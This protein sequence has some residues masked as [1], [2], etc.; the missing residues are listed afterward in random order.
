MPAPVSLREIIDHLGFILDEYTT[1][2]NKETG[3]IVTV[4]KEDLSHAEQADDVQD[5]PEWQPETLQEAR[6]IPDSDDYIALPGKFDIHEYAII[7]DF[8]HS[9]D[10]DELRGLL[11]DKI[12]G[13]GAFRRFKNAIQPSLTLAGGAR[14]MRHPQ[15]EAAN[16]T[17][18]TSS[19]LTPTANRHTL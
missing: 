4:S 11:L 3:A 10:D 2:L 1:Y 18:I 5:D 13:A 16:R 7:Q 17:P 8:C 12:R 9:I 6:A 19:R 15:P 14:V